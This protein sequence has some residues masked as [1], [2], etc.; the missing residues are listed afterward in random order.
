MAEL[1]EK[2]LMVLDTLMYIQDYPLPEGQ[3]LGQHAAALLE[4][5][6]LDNMEFSE[7]LTREET[8][9]MLQAIVSDDALS[10]LVIDK[11]IEGDVGAA[12]FVDGDGDAVIAFRGTGPAYAEWD[13]DAQGGYLAETDMQEQALDFARECAKDYDNITVTGHSK[14]GNMA[15]YV[16]VRMGDEVDRCVSFDGQGFGDEFCE[17]YANEIAAN[18]SKIRNVCAYNDY[19]N[20]LLNSIAGET[21]YL[22]TENEWFPGGHYLFDLYTNENNKL[23]E[24]GEFINA[25]PQD[26]NIATVEKIADILVG[27]LDFAGTPVAEFLFYSLIGAGLGWFKGDDRSVLK[28]IETFLGDLE[29]FLE[30]RVREW[31]S[32]FKSSTARITVDTDALR[33]CSGAMRTGMNN[34]EEL[35]NRISRVRREMASNVIKG[36][37]VGVQ[38]QVVIHQLDRECEKLDKLAAALQRCA[39]QYDTAENAAKG[40]A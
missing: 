20:I 29:E 9:Q 40:M 33:S 30:Y 1:N 23:D 25:R 37:S 6:V 18:S 17:K 16:T 11:A 8:E 22:D 10:S 36:V 14:G 35:R 12:C 7:G 26:P 28:M 31:M 5:G 21:V 39:D 15:Q 34:I 2:Q 32:G 3:S 24:N 27:I 13:D 19:V 4:P 38:L